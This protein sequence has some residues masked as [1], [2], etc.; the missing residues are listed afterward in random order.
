[1]RP[2]RPCTT[3]IVRAALGLLFL[4][5]GVVAAGVGPASAADDVSW[6]VR[7]ASN[8]FGADRQNFNYTLD[9]GGSLNDAL[10]VVNH[11]DK[12]LKLAVS[13]A[14]GFTTDAGQLDLETAD[15][16]P[17]EVGTWLRAGRNAIT[18]KPG[19]SVEVPFTLKLPDNATP[20]DHM[21][22]IIT[23]LTQTDTKAGINVDRRLAIRVKVRVG[24]ELKPA[25]AVEDLAVGYDGT[26]NPFARGSAT[27]TYTIHNT[28]NAI[29]AAR[30]KAS[31]AGPFGLLRKAADPI[32]DSPEL[33]P[34]ES[35][36]V[37]ATVDGVAPSVR[38]AGSV[39]LTPRVTDA[40]GTV[41][42]LATIHASMH[43]WAMPWAAFVV[44][45]VIAAAACLAVRSRRRAKVRE[46]ARV[47]AAI[48]QALQER[49]TADL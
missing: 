14:D 49:E 4:P 19:S 16:L 39:A 38:L 20:G 47:Q 35:W 21:G 1:M 44:L 27:I 23:S 5:V 17:V 45:L 30:Q 13:A 29:V 11:G 10:V 2:H 42:P 34:G 9:P 36:K 18:V 37:T 31:V 43:G 46:D 32:E 25:L 3:A 7:T 15:K 40:V 12:P 8:G 41:A 24:G 26:A 22:G 6:A 33:L 28:G 48:D